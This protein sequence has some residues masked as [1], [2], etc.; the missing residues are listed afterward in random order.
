MPTLLLGNGGREGKERQW[1]D[2]YSK[3][4]PF[5]DPHVVDAMMGLGGLASTSYK[6]IHGS[7]ADKGNGS[8]RIGRRNTRRL[9]DV[10]ATPG[11]PSINMNRK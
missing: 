6:Q 3:G 5:V 8:N 11:P 10:G 1:G 7:Q 4:N 2:K 9:V